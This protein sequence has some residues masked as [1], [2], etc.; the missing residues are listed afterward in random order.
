MSH[1]HISVF[2]AAGCRHEPPSQ[3]KHYLVTEY[4]ER[5]SLF[6]YL[7]QMTLSVGA[8]VILA[9]SAASGLAHL[10]TEVQGEGG[11]EKVAIAHRNI[12]SS[13]FWVKND[14]KCFIYFCN[15]FK[16]SIIHCFIT[17]LRYLLSWQPFPGSKGKL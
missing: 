7:S 17:C 11:V 2:I 4:Y 1:A 10:H 14:G 6:D 13:C 16:M 3:P 8:M 9:Q 5:G 15:D 12:S